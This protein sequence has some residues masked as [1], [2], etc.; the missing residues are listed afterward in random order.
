MFLLSLLMSCGGGASG[1]ITPVE[2]HWTVDDEEILVDDCDLTESSGSGM[3][4]G[5]TLDEASATGFVFVID[6][7]VEEQPCTI[8]DNTYSCESYQETES[9]SQAGGS[10]TLT[11]TW[12]S[13][14]SLVDA[15]TMTMTV[16]MDVDCDGSMCADIEDS[17]DLSFPCAVDADLEATAD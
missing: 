10:Y 7:D 1:P 11:Y 2:G 14:G 5:F 13:S 4:T 9:G 6:D 16:E 8:Q 15:Q 12:Q 3:P 17:L